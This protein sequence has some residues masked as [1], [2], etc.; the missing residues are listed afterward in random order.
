MCPSLSDTSTRS[1]GRS[2]FGREL[3]ILTAREY[4][5]VFNRNRR[6]AD[7]F[8]VLLG[9]DGEGDRPRLGITVSKKVSKKAVVRNRI[10][11]QI[12]EYFR[13]HRHDLK[14][15]DYVVIARSASATADSARL[16]ESLSR[17]FDR[18]RTD[19]VSAT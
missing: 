3:R 7:N 9:H 2:K 15:L 1:P 6:H 19:T 10:K 16:R 4:R 18:Y 11:R 5:T 17:H 12:R 8:A 14:N 13:A